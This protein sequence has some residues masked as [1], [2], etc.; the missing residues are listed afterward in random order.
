MDLEYRAT[1]YTYT[2]SGLLA[3]TSKQLVVLEVHV[4][5]VCADLH[6]LRLK[7]GLRYASDVSLYQP[8]LQRDSQSY[9][10][11]ARDFG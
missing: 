10:R 7:L 3:D 4:P 9:R 11:W 8:T 1:A 6:F 5:K 2:V